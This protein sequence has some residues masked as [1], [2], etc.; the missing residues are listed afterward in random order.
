MVARIAYAEDEARR[1]QELIT[2]TYAEVAEKGFSAVTLQDVASRA[3]VSKGTTLYYFKSKEDLFL[4][5]FEWLISG[6]GQ[7][8]EEAIRSKKKAADQLR[9]VLDCIFISAERNGAFYRAYLD[10]L[11]LATR[12]PR[13]AELARN[14][15]HRCWCLE[16]GIVTRGI[17]EGSFR[18]Q[19]P[20]RTASGI[21]ALVDGLSI[22]WL[23]EG[24]PFE[25]FKRDA[26]Q[27]TLDFVLKP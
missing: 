20:E 26:I 10:F 9:A 25:K 13:Y 2:A 11:G 22:R 4:A 21:R 5:V 16:T 7:R 24:G 6:I 1:R 3:G 17:T 14:F 27:T 19:S 15:Y 8:V 18:R 12:D 23:Y